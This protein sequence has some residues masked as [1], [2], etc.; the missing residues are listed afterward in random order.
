MTEI[1]P[2]LSRLYR[3][4]SSEGPPP[5]LDTA[6]LAAANQR[7]SKSQ[8]RARSPWLHWVLPTSVMATIV[9]S[10]SITL[11]IEREHPKTND[12]AF[13]RQSPPSPKRQ[14]TDLATETAKSNPAESAPADISSKNV[15]PSIPAV[16]NAPLSRTGDSVTAG[17]VTPPVQLNSEKKLASPEAS[18]TAAPAQRALSGSI[19]TD[20]LAKETGPRKAEE[21]N[22]LGG[23]A[24][25]ASGAT[26]PTSLADMAKAAPSGP[27]SHSPQTQRSPQVWLE[28]I[29]RLKQEGHSKEVSEQLDRFHKAY[30][31]HPI[32]QALLE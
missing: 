31:S 23:A 10:V 19:P 29:L 22:A 6:I 5:S 12:D 14:S 15:V 7:V 26:A 17:T 25:S 1:D 2:R 18:V 11:L 20:G 3:E 16:A 21:S 9:L 8:R 4:T 32:P 27:P 28:D 30:P 13:T 24:A